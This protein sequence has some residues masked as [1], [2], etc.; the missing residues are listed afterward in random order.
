MAAEVTNRLVSRWLAPLAPT[1][2][3]ATFVPKTL[4]DALSRNI[5]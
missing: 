2:T 4:P 5:A 1:L 3:I